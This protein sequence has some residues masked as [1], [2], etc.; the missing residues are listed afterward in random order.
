MARKKIVLLIVEGPS[1]QDSLELVFSKLFPDDKIMVCVMH[2]DVT[3]EGKNNP[4]NIVRAVT[5]RVQE[6]AGKYGGLQAG[7]F[8]EIIHLIDTDGSFI[9]D[10]H[11]IN[12]SD[13]DGYD[14]KS[15]W[16]YIKQDLNSLNRYTN[17]GLCFNE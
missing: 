11:I 15:S 17:I 3:T 2:C 5:K 12:D 13:C 6:Y 16:E 10:N 14:Y 9:P 8:Q 4:S 7:N 1:D